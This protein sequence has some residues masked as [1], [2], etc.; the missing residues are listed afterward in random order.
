MKTTTYNCSRYNAHTLKLHQSATPIE[1]KP[2]QVDIFTYLNK[3]R[4]QDVNSV[5]PSEIGIILLTV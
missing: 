1:F 2:L 5:I 3:R 4:A